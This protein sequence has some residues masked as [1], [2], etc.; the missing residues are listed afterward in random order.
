MVGQ[1]VWRWQLAL[2]ASEHRQAVRVTDCLSAVWSKRS[3]HTA[4]LLQQ[5]QAPVAL[6][7]TPL[8]QPTDTHLAKAAK[9]VGRKKKDELRALLRLAA[10]KLKR[11]V[12][13][14]TALRE[15]LLVAQ[16]MHRG[17]AELSQKTEVVLQAARSCGWL[18]YRPSPTSGKLVRAD[19]QLWAQVHA[20]KAGRLSDL[21]LGTRYDWLDEAGKPI[22]DEG[23][24]QKEAEKLAED[25]HPALRP[26]LA[27]DDVC[28][29]G[30]NLFNSLADYE[31]ALT[32]LTHPKARLDSATDKQV[33]QLGWYK[34]ELARLEGAKG[35]EAGKAATGGG[36][37]RL[38]GKQKPGSVAPDKTGKVTA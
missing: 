10:L 38:P 36:E 32:A 18:S 17:M 25:Q 7:C 2:D 22:L 30:V 19:T 34:K 12:E 33:E 15:V 35:A 16:A 13:Y 9:D 27:E 31:E 29:D 23:N 8:A 26:D 21:H 24:W 11:T 4:W 28:L 6:G 5:M 14:C 37:V 3:K 1:V 20:E